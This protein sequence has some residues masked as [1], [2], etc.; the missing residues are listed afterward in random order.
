MS[1]EDEKQP[2]TEF[3]HEVAL[4]VYIDALLLA[5]EEVEVSPEVVVPVAAP[6]ELVTASEIATEAALE[7]AVVETAVSAKANPPQAQHIPAAG[8][9]VEYLLFKVAGFLTLSVPLARLNGIMKWNGEITPIPGHAD[10]FLGLVS[11]RG[12]QVK[13]IDIAKFVIP[14]N[15][16]SRQAVEAERQFKHLLLVDGGRFGLACDEL[17]QVLKLN[18]DKIRWRNDRSNRPWLA[19]TIIEQMSALLDV[20]SFTEMLKEGVPLDEIP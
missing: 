15:H 7:T 12:R 18:G 8:E 1:A 2:A 5:P 20:D 9:I 14:A 6:A 13:V 19:G 3:E 11:N 10:W 17:G 4:K 16:K